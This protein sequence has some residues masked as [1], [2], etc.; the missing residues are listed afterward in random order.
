MSL[1]SIPGFGKSGIVRTSDLR[2]TAGSFNQCSEMTGKIVSE[3]LKV[4]ESSKIQDPFQDATQIPTCFGG[5]SVAEN[6]YLFSQNNSTS[7][8]YSDYLFTV[9]HKKSNLPQ[10]I[11][12]VCQR[13]F[14]WRRKWVRD[15]DQVR[16]C[17][18]RC[19]RKG[20]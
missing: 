6:V 5:L 7:S 18:E 19:R 11:C 15:W 10:K 16:Y 12:P 9:P 20:V 13:P 1:K 4:F 3:F 2:W 14:I 8:C 17:S